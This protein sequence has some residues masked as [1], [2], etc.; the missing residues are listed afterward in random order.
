M[1]Y[2]FQNLRR[3]LDDLGFPNIDGGTP[4]KAIRA[5]FESAF[6]KGLVTFDSE[7][8]MLE[9]KGKKY[10][11]YMY[12]KEAYVTF[13]GG[14]EKFPKFHLAKCSVIQEFIDEGKFEQRYEWSNHQMNDITDKQ[15]RRIYR[16]KI[17]DLCTLCRRQIEESIETTDEFFQT[18]DKG[19]REETSLEIDIF[20]YTRDWPKISRA[21]RK[22]LN[23]TCESC[24]LQIEN[25]FDQRY[26]HTHH[27]NGDKTMN[28]DNNLECLC[29]LCHCYKDSVHE[30]NFERRRMKSELTVFVNKYRDRLIQLN[31][32][33]LTQLSIP[34]QKNQI[35]R[36]VT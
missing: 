33:F 32:P 30:K 17:L 11:G 4:Y 31:N 2:K 28:A 8:I 6:K 35:R 22:K 25:K 18:L 24:L 19:T 27:R 12:I 5:D 7:G 9:H 16:E 20:G 10:R 26:L 15:S 3:L 36:R 23:Y 21:Y 13:N 14:P 34:V 29:V 1:L